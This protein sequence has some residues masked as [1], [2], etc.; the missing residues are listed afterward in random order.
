MKRKHAKLIG[1]G[2]YVQQIMDFNRAR[3]HGMH[4]P[5][6]EN[7]MKRLIATYFTPGTTAHI[8]LKR[9]G[10]NDPLMIKVP[11]E[12]LP[13]VW[14]TKLEAGLRDERMLLE[15]PYEYQYPN[16][17]IE[18]VCPKALITSTYA[19]RTILTVGH[20]RVTLKEDKKMAEW[21]FTTGNHTEFFNRQNIHMGH[22]LAVQHELGMP[23]SV[24]RVLFM[25]TDIHELKSRMKEEVVA[26]FSNPQ[27]LVSFRG[28][29][30]AAPNKQ[31]V[32]VSS[33]P[34]SSTVQN[35]NAF[36][37]LTSVL[38]GNQLDHSQGPNLGT[39]RQRSGRGAD[40]SSLPG[41]LN[42]DMKGELANDASIPPNLREEAFN[43]WGWDAHQQA[44]MLPH[45]S[46]EAIRRSCMGGNAENIG[47]SGDHNPGDPN[48][49]GRKAVPTATDVSVSQARQSAHDAVTAAASGHGGWG[50]SAPNGNGMGGNLGTGEDMERLQLLSAARQGNFSGQH[51]GAAAQH[52]NV[53]GQNAPPGL[54]IF[55]PQTNQSGQE[56][57]QQPRRGRGSGRGRGTGSGG[58]RGGAG[59]QGMKEFGNLRS[60]PSRRRV[61]VSNAKRETMLDSGHN[62][63]RRGNPGD[64]IG[65]SQGLTD[66]NSG[67]GNITNS[68][69]TEGGKGQKERQVGNRRAAQRNSSGDER[70]EKRQKSSTAN[71]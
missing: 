33:R 42:I 70:G 45:L 69:R 28:V 43:S 10:S 65:T 38:G 35:G 71:G 22:N 52:T 55:N 63:G 48:L 2:K 39:P 11:V 31:E 57:E 34:V 50:M 37:A 51:D 62:A 27:R 32:A 21:Q 36:K 20:L 41:D 54:K 25:A 14:K 59:G 16:G 23:P 58:G 56:S 67:V 13:R 4:Q 9:A 66:Q 8:Y 26:L 64:F 19:D 1:V 7:N 29:I 15:D 68:S 44:M 24:V 46:Q 60:M 5:A 47:S 30:H 18:V 53:H 12:L 61:A 40:G 3:Q 49:N 6:Y 17:T